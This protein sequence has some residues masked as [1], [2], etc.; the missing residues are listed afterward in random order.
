MDRDV[1]K[2]IAASVKRVCRGFKSPRRKLKFSNRQILLMYLWSV[3]HDRCLSW[4]CDR[5]HYGDLFRPRKLPSISQFT[6]RVAEET[7]QELLLAV[8]LD[9]ARAG[10]NSPVNYLDGKPLAVSPVSKD[11]DARRGHVSGGFAKGYKLHAVVSENRR[12]V[13]WSVMPLNV[14]EQSVAVEMTRHLPA[15][16]AVVLSLADS[17]YD[18]APL[19]KAQ[20]QKDRLLLTPLKAQGRVKNG[21]HH[22]VTLRQMGAQR[23]EMIEVWKNNGDLARFVLKQRNNIEGVFSVLSLA[24]HVSHLPGYVRR[25]PRVRRWIGAKIILYNARLDVQQMPQVPEEVT[26]S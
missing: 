26:K 25:L 19:H 14:A 23:R 20:A 11:P 13:V 24:L 7:F 1:W 5:G 18:S 3:N 16:C 22:P 12:I 9:L 4:A 21:K 10:F 6:R 15:A 17:N 8:H 2:R